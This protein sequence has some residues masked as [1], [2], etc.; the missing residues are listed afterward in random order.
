MEIPRG[1]LY[2]CDELFLTGTAAEITPI[3]SVDHISV[4]S[5]QPGEITLRLAAEFMGVISGTREDRHGWL[6]PV[7]P[8]AAPGAARSAKPRDAAAAPGGPETPEFSRTT[9]AEVPELAM[10]AAGAVGAA[11]AAGAAG[12]ADDGN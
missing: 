6:Q 4:G 11:G 1:M 12:R 5:G 8:A 3:R 7:Y 2:T 9:I 10:A